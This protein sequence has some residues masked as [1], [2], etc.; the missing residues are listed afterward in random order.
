MLYGLDLS[1][2]PFVLK[3]SFQPLAHLPLPQKVERMRDP[4]LRARLLSEDSV[5]PNP[6][7]LRL[8]DV[9]AELFEL[10]NVDFCVRIG[11]KGLVYGSPALGAR[12]SGPRGGCFVLAPGA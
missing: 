4:A 12:V 3:P 9:G 5:H 2:H 8:A 7:F 1:F 10:D 11:T 6:S